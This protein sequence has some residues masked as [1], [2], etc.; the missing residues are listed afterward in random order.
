MLRGSVEIQRPHG[1]TC[2][3]QRQ[4]ERAD[5]SL[6]GGERAIFRPSV[7]SAEIGN[8]NTFLAVHRVQARSLAMAVLD[9]V[10]V[11][12]ELVTAGDGERVALAPQGDS[13]AGGGHDR[14]R[15]HGEFL[16]EGGH[17]VAPQQQVL[18]LGVRL[19]QAELVGGVGRTLYAHVMLRLGCDLYGAQTHQNGLSSAGTYPNPSARYPQAASEANFGLPPGQESPLASRWAQKVLPFLVVAVAFPRTYQAL[20]GFTAGACC[21]IRIHPDRMTDLRG[22][23]EIRTERM[24]K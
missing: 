15:Q 23:P 5:D 11:P 20:A 7:V 9:L 18:E 19:D 24:S 8:E 2:D 12:G 3:G 21:F 10:H 22:Q 1:L 16:Q 17:I 6:R 4:R 13:A 14:G